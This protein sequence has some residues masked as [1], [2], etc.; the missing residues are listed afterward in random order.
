MGDFNGRT[1][2]N[3]VRSH[4]CMG[5]YGAEKVVNENGQRLIEFCIENQLVIGNSLFQHKTIH[6]ITYEAEGREAKSIIDYFIYPQT[7][8]FAFMDVKVIRGAEI[9]TDH[10]LLV[11]IIRIQRFRREKSKRYEKI[12]VKRLSDS[13]KKKQYQELIEQRMNTLKIEEDMEINDMWQKFKD[14]VTETAIEVC[15]KV[16]INFKKK[17]TNW[18]TDEIKIKVKEKKEAWK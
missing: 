18:W 12:Q 10:R 14:G 3:W 9:G 17:S 13:E 16:T 15:G 11:A 6:K 2:N 1:G 5:K 4:G 8:R 7:L